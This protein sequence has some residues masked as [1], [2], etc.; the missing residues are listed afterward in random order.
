[1][2][3]FK[4]TQIL[5]DELRI[6]HEWWLQVIVQFVLRRKG[7]LELRCLRCA[8]QCRSAKRSSAQISGS[9]SDKVAKSNGKYVRSVSAGERLFSGDR[10]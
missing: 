2:A 7:N 10:L 5:Y 8:D 3:A 4:R 9:F 6:V 1:V